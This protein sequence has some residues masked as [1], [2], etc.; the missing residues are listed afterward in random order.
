MHLKTAAYARALG[1]TYTTVRNVYGRPGREPRHPGEESFT[2]SQQRRFWW[3]DAVAWRIVRQ[4]CETGLTWDQAAA[5]AH[6]A[7]AAAWALRQPDDARGTFFAVWTSVTAAGSGRGGEHTITHWLGTPA[8]IA[9]VVAHDAAADSAGSD[10]FTG[11]AGVRMTSL[12]RAIVTARLLAR[13]AGFEPAGEGFRRIG[14]VH[15]KELVE[16]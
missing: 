12:H 6:D 1:E 4:L 5:A 16:Q 11:I 14:G 13:H 2:P 3:I 9:E 10:I 8:E 7:Y 15:A